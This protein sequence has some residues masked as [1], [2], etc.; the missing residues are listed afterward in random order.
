MATLEPFVDQALEE[1]GTSRRATERMP[2][3]NME[4]VELIAP[5][6][7]AISVWLGDESDGGLGVLILGETV[8][9]AE[10]LQVGERVTVKHGRSKRLATVRH[11]TLDSS[12]VMF[13][14]LE[15][16]HAKRRVS[17]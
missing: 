4:E 11:C 1:L 2:A 16:L 8:S 12:T 15:W 3:M 6:G 5:G 7:Q 13:V 14:G 17:R 10:W 9:Q